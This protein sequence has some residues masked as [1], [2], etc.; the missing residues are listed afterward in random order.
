MLADYGI[1][2]ARTDAAEG[3][4]AALASAGRMGYPVVLKTAAASHKTDLGGVKLGIEGPNALIAAFHEM[5][6][7]LGPSVTVQEMAQPGVEMALGIIRDP[8][9]GPLVMVA[10]GGVLIEILGDRRLALPPIDEARAMRLIDRL[11]V[12]PLL[13]GVRGAPPADAYSLALAMSRL[14]V[15]ACDLGDLIGAIDINPL[16]VGPNGCVA[17]DALVEPPRENAPG[18]LRRARETAG[19]MHPNA[20][21]RPHGY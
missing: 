4:D 8:Q 17:V 3:L 15:L 11:A 20:R 16:I 21:P 5:S 13:H 1:P 7:R 14:S 2:V 18:D 12:R 10:A 9:F 6:S 19:G